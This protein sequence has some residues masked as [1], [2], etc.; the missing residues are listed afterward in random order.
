MVF[1]G[2]ADNLVLFSGFGFKNGT[3]GF[4]RILRRRKKE[5]VDCEES[6]VWSF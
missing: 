6:V 1:K 5:K 4:V 2:T 3:Y